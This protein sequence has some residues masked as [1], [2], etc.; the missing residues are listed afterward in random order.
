MSYCKVIWG[1]RVRINTEVADHRCKHWLS[2][3]Y[4]FCRRDR[5]VFATRIV[6]HRSCI[7]VLWSSRSNS[8]SSLH[9]TLDSRLMLAQTYGQTHSSWCSQNSYSKRTTGLENRPMRKF[10]VHL[11]MWRNWKILHDPR[12]HSLI[13]NPDTTHMNHKFT[14]AIHKTH[15][16]HFSFF[17][18]KF[19][20]LILWYQ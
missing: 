16:K 15:P 19:C 7:T 9:Y 12:T 20:S 13:L 14:T 5:L 2:L 10:F 18:N 1:T 4:C 8:Q 6:A 17:T 3:D 11:L